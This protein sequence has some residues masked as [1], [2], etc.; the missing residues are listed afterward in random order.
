MTGPAAGVTTEPD[1]DATGDGIC[2]STVGLRKGFGGVQAV[3]DCTFQAMNGSITGLIGP[4]GAGKTTAFNLIT[5]VIKPSGGT[6]GFRGLDITAMAPHKVTRSGIGRTFQVTRV[7]QRLTVL[8][9]VVVHAGVGGLRALG[10]AR[11]SKAERARAEEILA[12]LGLHRLRDAPAG[13]LS[14]G[15][16]KLLELAGVLMARP[17]LVMLDEPAG[18]VNPRLLDEIIGRII[19]LNAQGITF[20]IVEHNMDLVMNVCHSVVVMAEGRVLRQGTPA[21]IQADDAV[22]AAYL[23]EALESTP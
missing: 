10:T 22:L 14:Y 4:N 1:G 23:G 6:V 16:R 3:R 17:Q 21:E 18:G 13:T 19:E 2:L 9:N 15:Q 12:F 7:F 11:I 20:L 8:E 5:G